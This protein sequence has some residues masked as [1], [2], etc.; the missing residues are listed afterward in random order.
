RSANPAGEQRIAAPFF[1]ALFRAGLPA[2]EDSLYQTAPDTAEGA[3]KRALAEGVIPGALA[4]DVP[5]A[6]TRFRDLTAQRLLDRPVAQGLSPIKELLA[7]SGLGEEARQRQF[8]EL[9]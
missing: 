6:L 8:T 7:V 9:Y 2:N 1:Y 5:A 4:G 3:W